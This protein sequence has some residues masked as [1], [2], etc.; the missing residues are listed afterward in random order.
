MGDNAVKI[1][2]SLR[3][4]Y[5]RILQRFLKSV[6]AYLSKTEKVTYEHF[7]K[8]IDNN[9]RY[10]KKTQEIKLYK[11]EFSELEALVKL[12]ISYKSIPTNINEIKDEILYRAN[13]LE[14]SKNIKKYKKDKHKNSKFKDW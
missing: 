12:I 1:K 14:K 13:H 10:L 8:K 4:K 9:L 5:I 11:G 3:V 6:V 7:I 2:N